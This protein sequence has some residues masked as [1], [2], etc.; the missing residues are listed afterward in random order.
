MVGTIILI[1]EEE[2][3]MEETSKRGNN[4]GRAIEKRTFIYSLNLGLWPFWL[5]RLGYNMEDTTP[6]Y[7]SGTPLAN[8]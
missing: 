1:V 8:G 2:D 7:T 5:D 6:I 3:L 4:G